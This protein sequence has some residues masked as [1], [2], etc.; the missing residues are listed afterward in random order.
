MIPVLQMFLFQCFKRNFASSELVEKNLRFILSQNYSE[1][2]RIYLFGD[3]NFNFSVNTI[4]LSA[5]IIKVLT[6]TAILKTAFNN[7]N[8]S[9]VNNKESYKA[10]LNRWSSASVMNLQQ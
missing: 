5:T 7:T 6:E 10:T 3:T 1:I 9:Y 8:S 4:I 2:S